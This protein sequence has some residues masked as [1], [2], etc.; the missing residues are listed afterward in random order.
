[1]IYSRF[2]KKFTFVLLITAGLSLAGCGGGGS[3]GSSGGQVSGVS[4]PGSVS[5]VSA[6]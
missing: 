4:T 3:S 5:V 1:M 2:F 6:N